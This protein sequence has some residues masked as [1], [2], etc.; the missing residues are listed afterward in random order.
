LL[1]KLAVK[2]FFVTVSPLFIILEKLRFLNLKNFA[3]FWPIFLHDTPLKSSNFTFY[4]RIRCYAT[5]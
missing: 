2:S 5:R 3:S 1:L 4:F